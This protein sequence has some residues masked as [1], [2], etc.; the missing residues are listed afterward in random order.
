MTRADRQRIHDI[1]HTL[2]AHVAQLDYPRDDVRGAADSETWKLTL[3][4]A[5]ARLKRGDHLC[6]D[7]SQSV[8][9]IFKWAGVKDPNGLAYRYAGYTGTMIA[10]LPHYSD[11]RDARTGAL[12]VFG[13]GTGEHVAMVLEPDPHHGNPLLFSHGATHLAGPIRFSVERRYHH[14]P[15]TFLSVK[16]L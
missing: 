14:Q 6:F 12:V 10:H 8:T 9:Q 16:R 3:A 4:Q 1:A 13:P 2:I 11:A 7:C 15:A 5:E